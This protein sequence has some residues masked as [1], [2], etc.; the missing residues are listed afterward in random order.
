[1]ARPE[2]PRKIASPEQLKLIRAEMEREP[3]GERKRHLHAL[4]LKKSGIAVSTIIARTGVPYSSIYHFASRFDKRGLTGIPTAPAG[5]RPKTPI[6]PELLHVFLRHPFEWP[7]GK[8]FLPL[9][10]R[11]TQNRYS[12]PR[13]FR[14]AKQFALARKRSRARKEPY[15]KSW[16]RFHLRRAGFSDPEIDRGQ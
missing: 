13:L 4:W 10:R 1:V 11:A 12:R 2:I 5:G 16:Y 8:A 15:T 9:C 3:D 7:P 14:W 6:P